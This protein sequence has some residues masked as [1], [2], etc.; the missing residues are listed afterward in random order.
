MVQLCPLPPAAMGTLL[1]CS[2]ADTEILK[3]GGGG[4]GVR[5]E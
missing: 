1:S 2:G 5:H 4:G 3:E